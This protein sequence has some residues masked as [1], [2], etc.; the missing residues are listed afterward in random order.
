MA[1]TPFPPP[2][3]HGSFSPF[4]IFN[5][6]GAARNTP[7][8]PPSPSLPGGPCNFVDL[9]YGPN[10]PKCGCRRFW[11]RQAIGGGIGSGPAA[12]DQ[13]GWCMCSHHA[14]FHDHD[15]TSTAQTQ[16]IPTPVV[17]NLPGQE[18]EKPRSHRVPLSPVLDIASLQM[19][20]SLGAA[21]L[22][23]NP[24][25]HNR[26]PSYPTGFDRGPMQPTPAAQALD[27]ESMPDTLS[28]R[29]VP[30]THGSY[31]PLPPIPSQCLLPDSQPDSITTSSQLTYLLPFGGKIDTLS[32]VRRNR[33]ATATAATS[34]TTPPVAV[35]S[36][37]KEAQH[38]ND[39]IKDRSGAPTPTSRL[40]SVVRPPPISSVSSP[41]PVAEKVQNLSD[42]IDDHEK[43]IDRLETGSIYNQ[44]QEECSE[45][46]DMVDLRMTELESRMEDVERKLI[47]DGTSIVSSRRNTQQ[48]DDATISVVSGPVSAPALA[49]DRAALHSQLEVLQAKVN[50][51]E[52]STLPSYTAPW[53]LE[54]VY[55]PF[56][57]KGIWQ[58]A[59]D[60]KSPRLSGGQDEWTQLPSSNSRATPDPQTLAAYDEWAGQDSGWLLPRACA[61][62]RMIDQRLRSR[63]LVKTVSVRGGD[64]KSVQI[65]VGNAFESILRLLPSP[66]SPR[67]PLASDARVDRFFGLQQAWVP[68]RKVHKDSRLRFLSPAELLTPVLW[69]AT[70]LMDSVVMKATGV[71]RLYITQPE[72]YLQDSHLL[73]HHTTESSWT[74]QK[75][76]E[77]PRVY[78]D[79][80]GSFDDSQVPEADALEECWLYNARLDEASHTRQPSLSPLLSHEKAVAI[81][82]TSDGSTQQFYTGPSNPVVSMASPI[83]IRGQSPLMQRIREDSR[84]PSIRAGSVPPINSPVMPSPVRTNR[85]TPSYTILPSLAGPSYQRHTSPLITTRHS[86]SPRISLVSN[87]AMSMVTKPRRRDTRS[88]SVV[89]FQN[90][91]RMSHRSYTR[92]PSVQPYQNMYVDEAHRG[93]RHMTPFANAYATPYSNAPM[94]YKPQGHI[95]FEYTPHRDDMPGN[96]PPRMRS[97]SQNIHAINSHHD[98]EDDEMMGFDEDHGSST[99]DPDMDIYTDKKDEL[100][101]LDSES[102]HH[103][104]VRQPLQERRFSSSSQPPNPEDEPWTG[105]EDNDMTD[106]D[107]DDEQKDP[108]STGGAETHDDD[109]NRSDVSSVPSEYPSTQSAWREPPAN[110]GREMTHGPEAD[111]GGVL[112]FTIHRDETAEPEGRQNQW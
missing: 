3:L 1:A 69:N 56:P 92:S 46:H 14:C 100:D 108:L 89:R 85:R 94:E 107:D 6:G 74:W 58:T 97:I 15:H 55:L 67:S 31:T 43:R 84:P 13:M 59:Q 10:G 102:D 72:A 80:Q 25:G 26:T 78:S 99:D 109:D 79:A 5:D 32:S 95:A 106:D 86:H 70:F 71:H 19:P 17:D 22:D 24:L 87:P 96:T 38:L 73:N 41:E 63:G 101:P 88:P 49:A 61:P 27:T 105:I 23:Q 64:A 34:L 35:S 81:S 103:H 52:A 42:A 36:T 62:G 104:S 12:M 8:P 83:F 45:K 75:L 54:V 37:A 65:A 28:W 90:T 16:V 40:S 82:R 77:L 30:S 68:L 112:G 110:D 98:E 2:P 29:N 91:P 111:D 66:V 11:S 18:N 53:T 51:L 57:L 9:T 76:R 33:D 60:F 21:I 4:D 47:D 48:D 44:A 39:A 93:E 50:Q 20:N 7:P